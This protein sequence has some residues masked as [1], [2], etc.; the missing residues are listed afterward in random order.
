MENALKGIETSYELEFRTVKR[1][2]ILAGQRTSRRGRQNNTLVSLVS[3]K[4]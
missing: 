3:P 4:M 1:D 2:Q